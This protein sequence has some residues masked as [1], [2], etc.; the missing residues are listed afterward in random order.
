MGS[1][2]GVEELDGT[3]WHRMAVPSPLSPP[4]RV[5]VTG[6]VGLIGTAVMAML[7]RRGYDVVE[8]DRSPPA[9]GRVRP[10]IV[11]DLL[12]VDLRTA[13]RGAN[14]VV[15]LGDFGT[16]DHSA[17]TVV[18]RVLEAAADCGAHQFVLMSSAAVYGAWPDNPVPLTESATPRPNHHFRWAEEQLSIERVVETWAAQHGV[19]LCVLRPALVLGANRQRS[20]LAEITLPGWGQRIG[21]PLPPRQFLH[22]DDVASAVETAVARR[23]DGLYNVAPPDWLSGD[24]VATYLGTTGRLPLV[25]P[26]AL[27]LDRIGRITR[28]VKVAPVSM[29]PLAREPW[30]IAADRLRAEGWRP[31]STSAEVLVAHQ[32]PPPLA[33][34]FARRRQ[35]VALACVLA[36]TG[37]SVVGA[38][39]A[40]L[41]AAHALTRRPRRT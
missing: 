40:L 38:V 10:P 4:T 2:E 41:R 21:R 12:T 7:R 19:G 33:R 1:G 28:R 22:P 29:R 39:A 37:F 3:G 24:D 31:R 20:R 30:V 27:V 36:V 25:M 9:P 26:L 17:Q 5:V 23:L 6:S 16:D 14:V 18:E 8:A 11:A 15:H 34:F 32:P 35:E 13:C